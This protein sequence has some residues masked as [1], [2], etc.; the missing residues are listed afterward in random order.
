MVGSHDLDLS[1]S[2]SHTERCGPAISLIHHYQINRCQGSPFVNSV[3]SCHEIFCYI[4]LTIIFCVSTLR[5][6]P[7]NLYEL[8]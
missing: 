5:P 8:A 1:H 2:D 4:H 3:T 7:V 6:N